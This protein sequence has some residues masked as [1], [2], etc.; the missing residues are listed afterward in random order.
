MIFFDPSTLWLEVQES[1]C[2]NVISDF[3][4]LFP[5]G[6]NDI[7]PEFS[8]WFPQS[9]VR[10]APSPT[11]SS[12]ITSSLLRFFIHWYC[13]RF[14]LIYSEPT[15]SFIKLLWG[16]LLSSGAWLSYTFGDNVFFM[17]LSNF[18]FQEC[19]PRHSDQCHLNSLYNS[20]GS[21]WH[22]LRSLGIFRCEQ[23]F[24]NVHLHFV[25]DRCTQFQ[26]PFIQLRV[27]ATVI[28]ILGLFEN[29][30]SALNYEKR[31][32]RKL[33]ILYL[34]TNY[35]LAFTFMIPCLFA[36]PEQSEA[37]QEVKRQLPCLPSEVIKDPNF[38]VLTTDPRLL[39]YSTAF[40]SFTCT[41][42]IF[43]FFF[44]I[45]DLLF[46]KSIKSENTYRIQ[47]KLY[48]SL[49]IQLSIPF[50]FF[51]IPITYIVFSFVT[52]FFNQSINNL[53]FVMI[54][55]HGLISTLV[56]LSVHAPY[57]DSIRRLICF[58]RKEEVLVERT[59]RMSLV[60]SLWT[61]IICLFNWFIP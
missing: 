32:P 8:S 37:I 43:Y 30:H 2:R 54:A 11:V 52:G 17:I 4:L 19:V 5:R 45:I 47:K 24:S 10:C 9:Y 21:C 27:S 14:Q 34:L 42:Q 39:A 38:F 15:L 12:R 40:I 3:Q 53:V 41:S 33:R 50:T 35:L 51:L 18:R 6:S 29:R 26:L 44:K 1:E 55:L 22:L 48:I 49:S 36:V 60:V 58:W 59:K 13:S 23:T 25:H 28:A 7:L 20:S 61:V 56:M 46:K 16:W 31:R 57:R